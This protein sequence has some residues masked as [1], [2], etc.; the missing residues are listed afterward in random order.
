MINAVLANTFM[1]TKTLNVSNATIRIENQIKSVMKKESVSNMKKLDNDV[2]DKAI[3]ELSDW[4]DQNTISAY[5]ILNSF[6]EE[7][8]EYREAEKQ[9]RMVIMPVAEGTTVYR[10]VNNTDACSKCDY[11]D[12]GFHDDDSCTNENIKGD[13]G[14]IVHNPQYKKVPVCDKQFLE[15]NPFK[16]NLDWIYN[17]RD[18]FGKTWFL[19]P[20]EAEQAKEEIMKQKLAEKKNEN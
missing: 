2:L 11:F 20:Q 8:K 9:G 17:N 16:P 12:K 5:V 4:L 3:D 1:T 6:L 10:I 14:N 7:L 15:V 19:T 18:N 13:E